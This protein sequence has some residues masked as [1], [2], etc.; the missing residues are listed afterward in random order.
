MLPYLLPQ[1]EIYLFQDSMVI[2]QTRQLDAG[3]EEYIEVCAPAIRSAFQYFKT[4]QLPGL[5]GGLASMY[6]KKFRKD[7]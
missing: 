6:L 2:L 4:N 7:L 3:L 5:N 1:S